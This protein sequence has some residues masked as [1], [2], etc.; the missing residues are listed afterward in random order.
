[1]NNK[2]LLYY[3][4]L[5]TMFL[6][7]ENFL[8]AQRFSDSGMKS[9]SRLEKSKSSTKFLRMVKDSSGVPKSLETSITRYRGKDG[10]LVDLIGVIHVG[11]GRYY[12]KLNYQFEQYESMLYELVAPEG[13]RVPTRRAAATKG[14]TNPLHWLQGSMQKMLGLQSQLQHID[15]T[16]SNFVHADLSPA[17]MKKKMAERGDTAWS[18]GMRAISEMMQQQ[19]KA[20]QLG[21]GGAAIGSDISSFDDLFGLISDP[22]KLKVMMAT[23]FAS[24]G[25]LDAGLG[26]TLNQLLITDRNQAAMKVLQKEIDKGQTKI[27]IFYGAAHMPDFEK[28]LISDFGLK[29]TNQAWVQAWDLQS[30]PKNSSPASGVADMLFQLL[31]SIE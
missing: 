15:Y 27:A 29:K 4:V 26:G 14:S 21:Q 16:K 1:M 25:N 28:R 19:S 10:L 7:N 31:D 24:T 6:S 20:N 30:A 3:L 5:T 17:Q 12:R 11:E 2:H 9:N 23:Q 22:I 13:S 8:N 18:V